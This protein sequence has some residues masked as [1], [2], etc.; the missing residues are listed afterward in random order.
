MEDD[1]RS[2]FLQATFQLKKLWFAGYGTDSKLKENG[3]NMA[4][5]SLLNKICDNSVDSEDNVSMTEVREYLCASK[6]SVSQTLGVLEKKGYINRDVD[7]SN[8][9]NVIVTLTSKGREVLL[10][11]IEE[12][13]AKADEFIAHFGEDNARQVI[14]L[15]AKM[16]EVMD[17][18]NNE[19]GA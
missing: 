1:M 9:R 13:N 12:F 2:Q 7:K 19:G 5:I 16:V 8:R 6:A 10:G 4:E 17:L 3:L 18:L 11:S 15:T 14:T